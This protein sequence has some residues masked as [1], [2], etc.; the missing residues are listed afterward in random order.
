MEAIRQYI[1]SMFKT[2]PNSAEVL[3]AKDHLMEMAEDKYLSLIEEGHTPNEAVGKVIAEFGNLDELKDELGIADEVDWEE[4]NSLEIR[5]LSLIEVKEYIHD[6]SSAALLRG[7]GVLCFICCIMPCIILENDIGAAIMF[8]SVAL[9]VVCMIIQRAMKAKWDYI[10]VTRCAIELGVAEYVK[11]EFKNNKVKI[12]AIQS[13]GIL[14]LLCCI[15]PCI[16]IHDSECAAWM[17][18]M[19]G[20]GVMLNIFSLG[21]KKAYD[22]I[23]SI[24]PRNT[25]GGKYTKGSGRI[26]YDN[27][28]IAAIMSIYWTL[29]VC[30]YL[31]ISFITFGWFI[32]WIIFPIA[33]IV[34]NWIET[35]YGERE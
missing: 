12:V 8:I 32:T 31:S 29:V 27:P 17:I 14:S 10:E 20:T 2:L 1:E 21:I 4:Q 34:N 26:V 24:N 23:L 30:V 22:I 33:A 18:L 13:V 7:F 28:N 3:K 9:G 16:I 5:N 6:Y 35:A 15:V 25:V 11:E 19:I